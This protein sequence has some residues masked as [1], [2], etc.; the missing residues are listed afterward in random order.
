MFSQFEHVKSKNPYYLILFCA[1]FGTVFFELG[2]Q[3]EMKL[4]NIC[5]CPEFLNET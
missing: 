4:L 2:L 5:Y 1:S 3:L